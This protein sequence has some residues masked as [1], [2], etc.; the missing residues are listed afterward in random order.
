MAQFD[1]QGARD[2]GVPDSETIEAL[3]PRLNYDAQGARDAGVPDNEI[4][5]A[6]TQ[7]F[8]STPGGAATGKVLPRR[9]S[10]GFGTARGFSEIGGATALGTAGGVILPEILTGA[11]GAVRQFP[12]GARVAPLLETA[13]IAAKAAGRPAT[14][15]G[16][17]VS[18][19]ASE[20]AGQVAEEF[21]AGPKTAFATRFVAGGLTPS[22]GFAGQQLLKLWA[23]KLPTTLEEAALKRSARLL[24]AK[25][26]GR[27]QDIDEAEAALLNKLSSELRG[28]ADQP[29][30]GTFRILESG[31]QR[32]IGVGEQEARTLLNQARQAADQEI[33]Q[34]LKGP[35]AKSTAGADRLRARGQDALATAQLQRGNIG[36]DAD[37]SDIGNTLRQTVVSRNEVAF[38][39]RRSQFKADEAARDAVVSAKEGRRQFVND[40]DEFSNLVD[41]L[42]AQL[43]PGTRSPDVQKTYDKIL[44]GIRNPEKDVFG[45]HKPTSFQALDDVRRQLGK[46]FEGTPPEGY[47]AI[48]A[49]DARKYYNII[50]N[51]QKSYAGEAQERLLT[52]YGQASGEMRLFGS[53]AG[54]K[55][56]ALDRFDEERFKVD[57]SALPRQFFNSKQGVADL[58][59]L[60][61]DR[62]LVLQAAKDFTTNELRTLDV[63]GI[64][65]WM[66]KRRELLSAM[67]EVRDAVVKYK[68]LLSQGE[69]IARR[70]DKAIKL[71]ESF[72]TGR[73]RES[74][75]TA[76]GITRGAEQEAERI[77]GAAGRESGILMG[78][79]FPVERVRTL[80][81][82]GDPN[83]W[84]LAAPEI[85]AAPGGKQML[86]ESV[87]Q[88]MADRAD[89]SI[90]GLSTFF[91]RQVRPGLEY[92]KA[93]S[94]L[95]IQFIEAKIKAIENMKLPEAEK[96]GLMKRLILQSLGGLAASEGARRGA[97]V[98]SNLV[99][100]IPQ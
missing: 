80:I 88:V 8:N 16:G 14:A 3:A 53:K 83:Q 26:E 20:T 42:K 50:S 85:L 56:T 47:E 11:A 46:V 48:S 64:E 84:R 79:E 10:T 62:T 59:E 24:A 89:K 72:Q 95:E 91:T 57:P 37:A 63:K 4:A 90:T 65:S 54:Q 82:S 43:T 60:T 40:T 52:N 58:V 81:E 92:T 30:E 61:G 68:N 28:S 19:F 6:L 98:A 93:V 66:V 32:R 21:G 27:P 23:A 36:Q 9:E 73:I 33:Q 31:A 12:Q 18:G 17:A 69:D 1:L 22:L 49:S 76:A 35:V 70:T 15:V 38:N 99:D 96:I 67:P 34:T 44:S 29:M 71:H 75:R 94:A 51:I 25:L 86:F 5:D 87:R 100:L 7:K 39:A 97:S 2:A 13:A 74:E 45:Q 78:K 77:R 55:L 41:D